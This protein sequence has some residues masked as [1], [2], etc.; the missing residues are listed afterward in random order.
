MTLYF[1]ESLLY[2][3]ESINRFMFYMYIYIHINIP[4]SQRF[5]PQCPLPYHLITR[6]LF[7]WRVLH[8]GC[9][10]SIAQLNTCKLVTKLTFLVFMSNIYLLIFSNLFLILVNRCEY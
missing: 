4:F 2:S 6:A 8:V 10:S 5:P 9:I 3:S 7:T 1:T